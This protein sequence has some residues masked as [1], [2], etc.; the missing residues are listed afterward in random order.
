MDARNRRN[1]HN[2]LE[3]LI[4]IPFFFILVIVTI[5]CFLSGSTFNGEPLWP[6]EHEQNHNRQPG[7]EP[8]RNGIPVDIQEVH[9]RDLHLAADNNVPHHIK[10]ARQR[11]ENR[12]A[13]QRGEAPPFPNVAEFIPPPQRQGGEW[14]R[15]AHAGAAEP[16]QNNP[17]PPVP[18]HMVPDTPAWILALFPD[19]RPAPLGQRNAQDKPTCPICMDELPAR[20]SIAKP[21]NHQFCVPC[22]EDWMHH[23]REMRPPQPARCPICTREIRRTVGNI[24]GVG[25]RMWRFWGGN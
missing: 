24:A 19:N 10:Q 11:R 3:S 17:H 13:A 25:Q 7:R 15:I 9:R 18:R 5:I 1:E 16:I 2:P 14:I 8:D 23:L 20:T 21:C 12:L 4:V 22:L 6:D